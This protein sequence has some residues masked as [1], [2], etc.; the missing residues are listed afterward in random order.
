VAKGIAVLDLNYRGSTGHGRAFTELNDRTLKVNELGDVADAVDW[1]RSTGSVDAE[2]VA[3]GGRS[4]G[5]YLTNQ[6]LGTYPDM[7]VAGV[8][9]VGVSDWVS[10]PEEAPPNVMAADQVEY[11]DI[12]DPK[13]RAFFAKLSPI[14]NVHK[15]KTPIMVIHG[16]N[17]PR[18]PDGES[19][20]FVN[21]IRNAGGQV[22]YLRF[23]DEGHGI[24]KSANR[25]HAYRRIAAFLE[26]HFAKPR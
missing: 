19:D 3:I 11:G 22:T 4:Y 2:R 1:P 9:T 5:G 7:F 14:N 16:A 13:V 15:M 20:R 10:A 21:A 23:G 24:S 18:D 26:E 25:I 17:D 8:S 12:R 6:A